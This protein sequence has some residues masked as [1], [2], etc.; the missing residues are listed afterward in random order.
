MLLEQKETK[1]VAQISLKCALERLGPP[2]REREREHVSAQMATTTAGE[3]K[4]QSPQEANVKAKVAELSYTVLDAMT[5]TISRDGYRDSFLV[6]KTVETG[7]QRHVTSNIA[8][9]NTRRDTK[10]SPKFIY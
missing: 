6:A 5:S 10:S 9:I 3:H 4:K 7:R 2:E 1:K 8:E